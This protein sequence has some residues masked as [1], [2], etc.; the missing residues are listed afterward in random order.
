MTDIIS[1]SRVGAERTTGIGRK[2][3]DRFAVGRRGK[4]DVALSRF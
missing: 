4:A 1:F 2:R 3:N